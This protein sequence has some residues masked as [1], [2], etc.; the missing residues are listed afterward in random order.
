[1][2]TVN[3][4]QQVGYARWS[5]WRGG[6]DS[7]TASS[8]LPRWRSGAYESTPLEIAGAY[9]VFANHGV[10][11]SPTT[12]AL[13]RGGRTVLISNR[14]DEHAVLDPRVAYLMVNMMQEV[15]RSG[16]G[17]GVRSRA[18]PLPAA[19][20]TGTSRDG[21]FAG[22][23]TELLCVVWVG[24]DDNRDLNWKAPAPRC[25]SGRSS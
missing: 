17:A 19:G 3:L 7:A 6:P 12:I 14:P 9:T 20:K 1:M 4:A 22:F 24:F 8:P 11:V 5:T 13:V 16:T 18:S 21:W 25:R 23:T 15:L 10:R 2:A